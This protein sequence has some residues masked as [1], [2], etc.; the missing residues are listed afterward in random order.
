MR[1]FAQAERFVSEVEGRKLRPAYV[2]VG[3]EVF[4]RKKCRDAI[5][6]H[7]VPPDLREFS[8]F[9]G[10]FWLRLS[11]RGAS[12]NRKSLVHDHPRTYRGLRANRTV[13]GDLLG[14]G[15]S[16]YAIGVRDRHNPE[17]LGELR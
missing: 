17:G 13:V 5:L 12:P 6:Q 8:L 10:R 4:F 15:G 3:D 11:H 16:A 14:F 2:F 9:E 1:A 7:L